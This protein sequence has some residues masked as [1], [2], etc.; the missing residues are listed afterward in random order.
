MTSTSA[1]GRLV[2][3]DVETTGT[4]YENDRVVT[5]AISIIPGSN[6][7]GAYH[8]EWL[9][10]PEVEIAEEA[11]A[12]HGI[13]PSTLG[14]TG[15]R[16][17]MRSPRSS[18]YSETRSST[19]RRS[20]RST[21]GLTSRCSTA[22]HDAYGVLALSECTPADDLVV[23]RPVRD[24]Q[25][26][27]PL[28]QGKRTLGV[29]CELYGVQLGDDAHAADA[30]ALAAARLAWRMSRR[31]AGLAEMDVRQLH[32]LQVQWAAEQA[33]RFRTT[34]PVRAVT[35]AAS[36]RG[37][38]SRSSRPGRWQHERPAGHAGPAGAAGQ[39]PVVSSL[40]L[41]I[42]CPEAWRRTYLLHEPRTVGAPLIIGSAVGA[43]ANTSDQELITNDERLDLDQLLD[44]FSDEFELKVETESDKA[45]MTGTPAARPRPRMPASVC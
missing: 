15:A 1:D 37:R 21:P 11:T 42:S 35:S 16:P 5:A 3:F 36:P 43:A 28:P 4:D 10:D 14:S 29:L 24:R 19:A 34:S 9:I 25:A 31:I 6:G 32:A 27:R 20:W 8:A 22:K 13:R 26:L 2:A 45:Q 18:S 23:R 17:P 41:Y 12:V 33:A 39:Q 30:D 7:G 38:W 40:G 44:C